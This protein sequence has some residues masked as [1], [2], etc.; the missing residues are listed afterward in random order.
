MC[1]AIVALDVHPRFPVVIASNRD[2]FFAREAAPCAYWDP[3]GP[4]ASVLG[5]RDRARGGTWLAVDVDAASWAVVTNVREGPQP[6]AAPKTRGW[7]PLVL[8]RGAAAGAP[9]LFSTARS[10]AA[11]GSDFG[12]FHLVGG[13]GAREAVWVTNRAA[14]GA[15]RLPPGLHC[16]TN[17][18][19]INPPWPKCARARRLVHEALARHESTPRALAQDLLDSV[20]NDAVRAAE[21]ELPDTGVGIALE[22]ALSSICVEG[23]PDYGTVAQSVIVVDEVGRVTFVERRGGSV[24]T[25]EGRGPGRRQW[26]GPLRVLLSALLLGGLLVHALGGKRTGGRILHPRV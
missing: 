7:L 17:A 24:V 6:A 15:R 16:V 25:H 11:V 26:G 23:L 4:C 1:I 5:G 13:R 22:R 3:N 8:L 10:I 9:S 20:L 12:G 19:V 21:D 14:P 18:G 2:E